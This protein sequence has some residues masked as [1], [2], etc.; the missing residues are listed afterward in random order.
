[1][2]GDR[3]EREPDRVHPDRA[4]RRGGRGVGVQPSAQPDRPPGR[5]SNRGRLPGA[6]SNR[7]RPRRCRACGSSSC[8]ARPACRPSGAYRWCLPSHDLST[9]MVVRSP[10]R[11]LQL[12][13]QREGRLG[14]AQQARAGRALRARARRRRAGRA[15]RRRRSGVRPAAD[16]EGRLLSRGAGLRVGP[17][18]C[19]P[20]ARSP[21]GSPSAGEA[22]RQAR[23]RRSDARPQPRSAR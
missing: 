13:R 2:G 22:R 9:K 5:P 7:R 18:R 17:A 4:D 8:C 6:R 23:G 19:S 16:R 15:R 1:M 10:G 20:S 21:P 12:H 11:V 3:V 14:A